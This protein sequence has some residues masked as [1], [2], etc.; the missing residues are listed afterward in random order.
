M[1][2]TKKIR[3][4]P[5]R[6]SPTI[7]HPATGEPY[8]LAP[9]PALQIRC[10]ACGGYVKYAEFWMCRV[11]EWREAEVLQRHADALESAPGAEVTR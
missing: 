7:P 6:L 4:P 1:P 2:K 9:L 3:V 8:Y 10:P 5:A 11:C